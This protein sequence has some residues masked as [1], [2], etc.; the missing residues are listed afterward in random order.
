MI[1]FFFVGLILLAI[2]HVMTIGQRLQQDQ[3]TFL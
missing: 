1:A 3:E 2:S